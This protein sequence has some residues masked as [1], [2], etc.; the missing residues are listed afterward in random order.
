MK[1]L[2]KIY[3][4]SPVFREI[5]NHEKVSHKKKV[6]IERLWL[7]LN[8][9]A[10]IYVDSSR[11]SS[12]QRIYD[13][14]KQNNID[15][16]GCHISHPITKSILEIPSLK[17]V[18]TSSM[19]FNHIFPH[20]EILITHTPSI[21]DKT[22]AELTIGIIIANLRNIVGLHN[23]LWGG[24][25]DPDLKWDLDENLNKSF[26]N[27]TLGIVGLGEIGREVVRRLD[28]WGIKIIYYDIDRN[29]EFEEKF[30]KLTFNEKMEDIFKIADII[31]L[32]IPLNDATCG[33][34]NEPLLK[35][36]KKNAL[37]VNT[38]RGAVINF[39]DLI[40]LLK[41]KDISINLAFDVFEPEPITSEILNEF[42]TIAADRPELRF[43]FIPHSGSSDA[44]TRAKMAIVLFKNLIKLCNSVK[45]DVLKD[46]QLIPSQKMCKDLN[47]SNLEKLKVYRIWKWWKSR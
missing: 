43:V 6:Q 44:D 25:W 12:E 29:Q 33:I 17:A 31:S 37:L 45:P 34:V 24:K 46:L 26:D 4:T 10:E 21:M 20:P 7:E 41:S 9:I 30:P 36:M 39:L 28:P 47:E 22:V 3:L 42:K 18:C 2:P 27:L 38:A 15:F 8:E 13:V 11:F 40:K 23:Y 5:A 32:H 1:K 16:I 35:K 14:V 19:G